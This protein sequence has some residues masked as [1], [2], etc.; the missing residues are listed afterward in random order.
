MLQ[1]CGG[2][3][4]AFVSSRALLPASQHIMHC[5]PKQKH[6]THSYRQ[7]ARGKAA[8]PRYRSVTDRAGACAGPYPVCYPEGEKERQREAGAL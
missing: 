8:V 4:A 2:I 6:S 1:H 7:L 3:Q 5:M